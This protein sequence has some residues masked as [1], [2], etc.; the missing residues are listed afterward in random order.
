[1]MHLR[2]ICVFVSNGIVCP[3]LLLSNLPAC[4]FSH[5]SEE[6]HLGYLQFLTVMNNTAVNICVVF[7]GT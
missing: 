6:V 5:S 4:F 3:F 7:V 2:F 1:M